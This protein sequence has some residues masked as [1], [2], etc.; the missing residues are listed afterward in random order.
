M[1]PLLYQ[2]PFNKATRE[3]FGM[4]IPDIV[5]KSNIDPF[6]E[7]K[8]I[9]W[10]F[11]N[12]NTQY[13]THT[14]HSYPARF[15]PQIPHIFIKLFT[16][17]NEFVLDPMCG[18]G[19]TLVEA[20]M[21]QRR[22]IGN[23]LN[24]LA[25]LISRVKTTPIE[26]S[27]L[28]R[29]LRYVEAI[30]SVIRKVENKKNSFKGQK[31]NYP[32]RNL[33]SKF[34]PEVREELA[35]IKFYID[36]LKDKPKVFD[37]LLIALSSTVLSIVESR[38]GDS[39]YGV[40]KKKVEN[41]CIF[42]LELS[43]FVKSSKT[44]VISEDARNLPIANKKV[45]L[46][47]TSPPYVNALDYHRVHMYNMLWLGLDYKAFMPDEIGAH[48]HFI[49]N[50]FRLLSEY[51]GDMLR[52]MIEMNRVLKPKKVCAIVVGNS[53]L[54][55]E[56]IESYKYFIE[57]AKLI[58]F[59]HKATVFRNI[60]INSKYYS[61]NIGK[62]DN[63]YIVVFQKKGNSKHSARDE[64]FIAGVIRKQMLKFKKQ[65]AKSP[66]SSL[67]GKKVPQE[68]LRKNV[69]R[70]DYAIRNIEKDIKI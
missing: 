33:S 41:M 48:S 13:L 64:K 37:L 56:L 18:C 20:M 53:S 39:V 17:K 58:G 12:A 5:S 14:F 43:E 50:R 10:D 46:I 35:A 31:F 21:L 59:E 9:D 24:P 28:K 42:L 29:T 62:I 11:K 2:L 36:K 4:Q 65:I 25:C 27:L 49:S 66:G 45:D 47:V 67:R 22:G 6:N 57:F 55:Y 38:N 3:N 30:G 54:E 51:F 7:I 8:R 1:K 60:D 44:K 40:F 26:A 16:K 32:R 70:I 15:I 52:C 23:D 34:S 63:E 69:E 61:Q 19:T 68:R